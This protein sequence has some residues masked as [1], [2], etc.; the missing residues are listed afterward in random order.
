MRVIDKDGNE[1]EQVDFSQ[2]YYIEETIVIAHHPAQEYIPE[3]S[4]Y[5]VIHEY[6]NGGKDVELVIDVPGQEARDAWDETE[7]VLRWY[8]YTEE[9]K[10]A[11]DNAPLINELQERVSTLTS[12]LDF[13][14]AQ[15]NAM[16]AQLDFYEDCIAE[17]AEIVYA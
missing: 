3:Q 15:T 12:Q 8:E 1:L 14:K 16:S 7:E 13:Q 2:G 10:E 11:R 4:H 6:P 9:E 17:M 5:E